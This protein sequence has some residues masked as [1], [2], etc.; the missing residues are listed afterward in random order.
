MNKRN[1]LTVIGEEELKQE[2]RRLD[3]LVVASKGGLRRTA[4]YIAVQVLNV[5][6]LCKNRMTSAHYTLWI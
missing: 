6:M 4:A 5:Q 2:K 1:I 3:V